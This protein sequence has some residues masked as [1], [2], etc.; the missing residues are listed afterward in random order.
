MNYDLQSL[1]DF[2]VN[3]TNPNHLPIAYGLLALGILSIVRNPKTLVSV[4]GAYLMYDTL[5]S[6]GKERLSQISQ[7]NY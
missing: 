3:T 5:I 1:K 6:K 2:K 4:V 7:N